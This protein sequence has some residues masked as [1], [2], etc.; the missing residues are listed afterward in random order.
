MVQITGALQH[1]NSVMRG[2]TLPAK[3]E[4]YEEMVHVY[5]DVLHPE[6]KMFTRHARLKPYMWVPM[7]RPE[8]KSVMTL[9]VRRNQSIE[10]S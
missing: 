5:R 8:S 3:F 2:N 4:R 7:P 1:L 9:A 6:Y 10:K